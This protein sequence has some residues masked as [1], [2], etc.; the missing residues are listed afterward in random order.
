MTIGG[1]DDDV[2]DHVTLC[3]GGSVGEDAMINH[4]RTHDG[5]KQ[6]RKLNDGS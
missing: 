2:W 4:I 1:L 6:V 5:F 3:L